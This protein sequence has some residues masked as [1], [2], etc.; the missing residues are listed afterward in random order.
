[1]TIDE[2]LIKNNISPTLEIKNKKG[3][4]IFIHELIEKYLKN[5]QNE[6]QA[7]ERHIN[8]C[9]KYGK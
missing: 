9:R 2:F 4:Y 7:I 5:I 1:M 3:E 6:K 8:R